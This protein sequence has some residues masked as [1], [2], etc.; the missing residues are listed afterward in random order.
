MQENGGVTLYHYSEDMKDEVLDTI[1]YNLIESN[2]EF[3]LEEYPI[4]DLEE[5]NEKV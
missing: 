1:S 2:R 4:F 3:Q 5:L